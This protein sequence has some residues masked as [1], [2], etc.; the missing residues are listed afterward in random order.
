M[1]RRS[2]DVH[3]EDPMP[4]CPDDT[5]LIQM[6]RELYR[7]GHGAEIVDIRLQPF[8]KRFGNF[9]VELLTDR[10]NTQ[11][12]RSSDPFFLYLFWS[13]TCPFSSPMPAGGHLFGVDVDR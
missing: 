2:T 6:A 11:M 3:Q 4:R 9:E 7:L 8:C 12:I 1:R 10:S 5:V 13:P